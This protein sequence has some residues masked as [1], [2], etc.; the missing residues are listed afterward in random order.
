MSYQDGWDRWKVVENYVLNGNENMDKFNEFMKKQAEL[1]LEYANGMNKLIKLT[2]DDLK[3]KNQDKVFGNFNMAAQATSV[4]IAWNS[5]LDQMEKI[6]NIRLEFSTK[7]ETKLR[8]TI[9]Y[10]AR[11]NLQIMKGTLNNL[12][13]QCFFFFPFVWLIIT[14]SRPR[15]ITQ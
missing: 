5:F 14:S 13:N 15:M 3:R 6:S 2:K 9:K 4:N 1:E 7:L 11:D 12:I 8:K 10:R